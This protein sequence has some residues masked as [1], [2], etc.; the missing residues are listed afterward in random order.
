MKTVEEVD[1]QVRELSRGGNPASRGVLFANKYI[2][3]S[4][5]HSFLW[6]LEFLSFSPRSVQ[7]GNWMARTVFANSRSRPRSSSS[8]WSMSFEWIQPCQRSRIFEKV[9]RSTSKTTPSRSQSSRTPHLSGN[10]IFRTIILKMPLFKPETKNLNSAAIWLS[11]AETLN[12]GS[13]AIFNLRMEFMKCKGAKSN[14]IVTFVTNQIRSNPKNV[15]LYTILLKEVG[16]KYFR[17][18]LWSF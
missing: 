18:C 2:Q 13:D 1:L 16:M 5:F 11:K 14:E 9:T 17:R 4:K 8:H 15:T 10:H 7:K 3:I 6:F 12:R